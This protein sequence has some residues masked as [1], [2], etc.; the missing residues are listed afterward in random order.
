ME[1]LSANNQFKHNSLSKCIVHLKISGENMEKKIKESQKKAIINKF[2][3]IEIPEDIDAQYRSL[4]NN[5]EVI[6]TD[7]RSAFENNP[8]L[9]SLFLGAICIILIP[10]QFNIIIKSP[11]LTSYLNMFFFIS[12]FLFSV[13]RF[14]RYLNIELFKNK[15]I[16]AYIVKHIKN[17]TEFDDEYI[18]IIAKLSDWYDLPPDDNLLNLLEEDKRSHIKSNADLIKKLKSK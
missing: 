7:G 9:T 4:K 3:K 14:V 2:G 1:R 6:E 11:G 18:E 5:I 13:S 8:P 12:A 15:T 16:A 17:K 10:M